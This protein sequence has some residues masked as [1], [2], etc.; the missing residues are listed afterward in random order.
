[1]LR[2]G[3]W[4]SEHDTEVCYVGCENTDEDCGGI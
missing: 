1:M 2:K 3:M 4:A